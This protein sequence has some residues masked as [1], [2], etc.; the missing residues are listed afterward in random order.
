MKY[1]A[2]GSSLAQ[3]LTMSFKDFLFYLEDTANLELKVELLLPFNNVTSV[4]MNV[5]AIG[6][7]QIVLEYFCCEEK[8]KLK[9]VMK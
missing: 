7:L 3:R 6:L 9:A 4:S 2:E 1:L 8:K 5:Y